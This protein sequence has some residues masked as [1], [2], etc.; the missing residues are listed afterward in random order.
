MYTRTS[1][2]PIFLLFAGQLRN[3]TEETSSLLH[4]TENGSREWLRRILVRIA[5]LEKCFTESDQH[6]FFPDIGI[7]QGRKN[8]REMP[9]TAFQSFVDTQSHHGGPCFSKKLQS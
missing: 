5:D 4:H 3:F 6:D 7:Q 8:E 9:G 1:L 2:L